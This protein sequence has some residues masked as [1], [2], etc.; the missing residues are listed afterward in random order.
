[1]KLPKITF[2]KNNWSK[3]CYKPSFSK[4][5]GGKIWIFSIYKYSISLDFRGGFR[6]TDLLN[7]SEKISYFINWSK[8]RN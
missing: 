7:D 4:Y 8:N 3:S 5:W 2:N 6:L 1:M